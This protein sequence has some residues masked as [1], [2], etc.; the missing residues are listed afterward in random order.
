MKPFNLTFDFDD[1]PLETTKDAAGVEWR[2]E[3]TAAGTAQI[4][5]DRA[6]REF[7]ESLLPPGEGTTP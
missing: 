7:L 6:E 5:Y 2:L 4:E 1:L 3:I